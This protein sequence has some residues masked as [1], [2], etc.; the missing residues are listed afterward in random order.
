MASAQDAQDLRSFAHDGIV[1]LLVLDLTVVGFPVVEYFHPYKTDQVV[2]FNGNNYRPVPIDMSGFELSSRALPTPKVT[3]GNALGAISNMI[4]L[5]DGLQGAKLSRFKTFIK[6]LGLPA[7]PAYLLS[8]PDVY[9]VD[10][11]AEETRLGVVIELQSVFALNGLKL[12]GRIITQN[13]CTAIF[14]SAECGYIGANTTCSRTLSGCLAN[15]GANS[16]LPINAFPGVDVL[17]A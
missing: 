12:P 14:K 15:F 2:N 5:Y 4:K 8:P 16:T 9:Y 1:D 6:Y 7:N 10:R 3:I 11:V 13:T 17:P